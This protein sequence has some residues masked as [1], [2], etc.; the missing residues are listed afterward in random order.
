MDDS[1][2]E[3][4]IH[5]LGGAISRRRLAGM[6]S[7]SG[8]GAAL[9]LMRPASIRGLRQEVWPVQALQARQVQSQQEAE[10]HVL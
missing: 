3:N 1:R 5:A 4:L 7:G 6:M 10:R 8:L 2:F 9:G